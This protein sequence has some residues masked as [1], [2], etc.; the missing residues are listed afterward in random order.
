MVASLDEAVA[1][2]LAAV[3]AEEGR[4][5]P[6]K[7][8]VVEA[9]LLSFAEHG[10]DASSTR[11]IAQ[12]AG[13]AEGTIFRHFDSKSDL[14][15]RLVRPV[16]RHLIAPALAEAQAAHTAAG[17]ELEAMIRS[18]MRAR[19]GFADR[20]AP[21]L[22]ILMQE[23]PVN[24][25]LRALF[26][27]GVARSLTQFAETMLTAQAA[28]GRIRPISAPRFL[29]LVVSLLVGYWIARSLV[30]PGDWDDE[31]EIALMASVLARGLQPV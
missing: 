30:A 18:I 9:A 13:V 29:R 17:G 11:M 23:L 2:V 6:K 24:P 15:L 31:A 1:Q 7:R 14:L 10:F 5:P 20:F 19:L 12:R 3:E 26:Q 16:S 21:L 8:A 22:R 25:D 4:L 28:A 27:D